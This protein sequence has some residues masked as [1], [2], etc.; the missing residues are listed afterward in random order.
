VPHLVWTHCLNE[1]A[2]A[3]PVCRANDPRSLSSVDGDDADQASGAVPN[4]NWRQARFAETVLDHNGPDAREMG[5]LYYPRRQTSV[6]YAADCDLIVCYGGGKLTDIN[7]ASTI[8]AVTRGSSN[9][10]SG[11]EQRRIGEELSL[12]WTTCLS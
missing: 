11:R 8:R 10:C 7:L 9:G 6:S 2:G 5:C 12:G 1:A 4:L 3:L